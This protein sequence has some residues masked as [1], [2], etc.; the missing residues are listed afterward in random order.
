MNTDSSAFNRG[1][2]SSTNAAEDQVRRAFSALPF[3]SKLSTLVGIELDMLR[4]V[5]DQIVT[6]A[7]KCVDEVARA[8]SCNEA[9]SSAEPSSKPGT[10]TN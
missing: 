2:G 5:T 6:A 1:T 4:D 9:P 3:D 10:S 8:F 7:S